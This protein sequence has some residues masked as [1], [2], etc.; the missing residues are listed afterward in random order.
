[1]GMFDRLRGASRPKTLSA[2]S[3]EPRDAPGNRRIVK[4]A[5]TLEAINEAARK[6]GFVIRILVAGEGFEPP[7]F[8][9]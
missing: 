4:T 2:P 7:T 8:G 6:G 9:L 1:M 3:D 5:R